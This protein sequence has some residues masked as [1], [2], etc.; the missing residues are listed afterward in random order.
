MLLTRCIVTLNR[1]YTPINTSLHPHRQPDIPSPPHHAASVGQ[2]RLLASL[3]DQCA[4]LVSRVRLW[5]HHGP[6]RDIETR[7][8]DVLTSL[9]VSAYIDPLTVASPVPTTSTAVS[10]TP[11]APLSYFSS[12]AVV[13]LIAARIALPDSLRII[14]LESLLPPDVA[15]AYE[16]AAASSLLRSSLEV[17]ERDLADPLRRPRIA[18]ARTEYVRLIGRLVAEGMVSFTDAPLAV[19]GVFAVLKDADAD[20]LIIDAQPANRLFIDS[21]AVRLPDP[22]HLVQLQVPA[23]ASLI[24]AK[25]DLSNFYHHLGLPAWM[26]PYFALPE[27][28]CAELASIGHSDSSTRL[29]PMCITLPMGFS[30]AVYLAQTVH[31]HVVYSS[32]ALSQRDSLL[33]LADPTVTHARVVHGIVIDDM[34]LFSLNHSLATRHFD[35]VLAAYRAAGFVVKASKVVAPTT[36]TVKVI[37]FDIASSPA[38]ISLPVDSLVSLVRATVSVLQRGLVTGTT[39]AHIVG[40]WTWVML[41][42][43]ASLAVLQHVYRFTAVSGRRRF[44]LWPS[45]RRE[46]C[47]LIGLLPVLHASL[48]A[49]LFSRAVASDASELAGG[50]VT[51]P[52]TPALT[53]RFWPVCSSR[54]HAVIQALLHTSTASNPLI[55]P[56]MVLDA[57]QRLGL[58]AAA[59]GYE[60]FYGDITAARWT[61]IVARAWR[62]PEHINVLELR[63][64]LLAV[65]W[66]LTYPSSL[67]SRVYLLVDSTVAF[68]SLWKGRS[69]SPPVLLVLRK[70]SVLCSPAASSSL[71]IRILPYQAD[72]GSSLRYCAMASARASSP[73]ST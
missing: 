26:Q 52:L 63:A 18:G 50:V 33:H 10:S 65:H 30:H 13:P 54:R 60:D 37:G 72:C 38:T 19:N 58:E 59:A 24:T 16:P 25:S 51:T 5:C 23:G 28:T 12:P 4:A 69:S 35:A 40:R 15:A 6:A 68:F 56:H 32:G 8:L 14:P 31:E 61:T 49:P 22:S 39:L 11:T 17:Y 36:D 62:D 55:D 67:T 48:T 20:R 71:A 27:L 7:A 9:D 46:L 21:P 53:A 73:L 66:V 41:L 42:R 43:R 57:E 2:L 29:H 45:V 44:T 3:G 70:I 47:S 34:F 64:A 1:L